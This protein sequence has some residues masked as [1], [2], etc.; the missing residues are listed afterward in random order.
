MY[1]NIK[2]A[3][4]KQTFYWTW[5]SL[6]AAS[7]HGTFCFVPLFFYF[8]QISKIWSLYKSRNYTSNLQRIFTI[9]NWQHTK[10]NV[11]LTGCTWFRRIPCICARKASGTLCAW[12]WVLF[13]RIAPRWT[14]FGNAVDSGT[15]KSTGT[16]I[17]LCR[18]CQTPLPWRTFNLFEIGSWTVISSATWRTCCSIGV[19]YFSTLAASWQ[20]LWR[21]T[22]FPSSAVWTFHA[23][24]HC[25]RR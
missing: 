1:K 7:E 10:Y 17:A 2:L 13:G 25:K 4:R 6:L 16:F 23:I 22:Y 21:G 11:K 5:C 12:L 15:F 3:L 20:L 18:T 24:K 19:R 14:L 9:Y 8:H